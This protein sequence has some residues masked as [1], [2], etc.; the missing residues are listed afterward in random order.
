MPYHRGAAREG[1][2]FTF[3]TARD[4]GRGG[5]RGF[6]AFIRIG[7]EFWSTALLVREAL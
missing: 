5:R 4:W 7:G 2:A 3:H 1:S 6:P